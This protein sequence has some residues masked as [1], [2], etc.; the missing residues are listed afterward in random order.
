MIRFVSRLR[1][2]VSEPRKAGRF[3]Y[4][5]LAG[6]TARHPPL[7]RLWLASWCRRTNRPVSSTQEAYIVP[8][9]HNGAQ[10]G[11][12]MASWSAV[13]YRAR[14][15]GIAFANPGVSQDHNDFF[16][17]AA[18]GVPSRQVG[19]MKSLRHVRLPPIGD[20]RDARGTE[21]WQKIVQSH[22]SRSSSPI[23]FH[24]PLDSPIYDQVAVEDVFR[25]CYWEKH[26]SPPRQSGPFR[27]AVHVRRGDVTAEQ[28]RSS[29][30]M[31]QRWLDG[32]WYEALLE[33]LLHNLG[34]L[35]IDAQVTIHAIGDVSDLAGLAN[36]PNIKLRI[37]RPRDE[38]FEALASSD[39]LVTAPSSFSFTAA[40]VSRGAVI[41]PLPWWHKVP[42]EGRW[43][44]LPEGLT[45]TRAQLQR[46]LS[47]SGAIA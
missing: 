36:H 44:A 28:A 45:P 3:A 42:D 2:A 34:A 19:D 32:T 12:Q 1:T 22:R 39:L 46:A 38:D 21:L 27:L 20:E 47:A 25:D 15:L 43:I 10:V 4:G 33:D 29:S 40:L 8:W 23:L 26:P 6:L 11:H 35:G 16:G 31:A 14:T 9:I 7:R 24:A 13:V 37:N 41:A 30:Q 18:Y 17:L 5:R